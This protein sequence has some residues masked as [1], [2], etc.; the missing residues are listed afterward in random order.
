MII[1]TTEVFLFYFILK[2]ANSFEGTAY[3]SPLT[4]KKGDWQRIVPCILRYSIM[5]S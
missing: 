4:Q 1:N 2:Q 3:V 5:M